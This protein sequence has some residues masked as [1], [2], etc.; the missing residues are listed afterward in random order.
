MKNKNVV[1]FALE[2][3]QIPNLFMVNFIIYL[4]ENN[5]SYLC[6]LIMSRIHLSK[7]VNFLQIIKKCS[8]VPFW[9]LD[10]VLPML[11]GSD[12]C[13][14]FLIETVQLPV[15]T[16][17]IF[18]SARSQCLSRFNPASLCQGFAASRQVVGMLKRQAAQKFHNLTSKRWH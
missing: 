2:N 14:M 17:F 6:P 11:P 4:F 5:S 18:T 10:D 13:A 15:R 16:W 12:P 1:S 7:F 8:F 3:E 9:K